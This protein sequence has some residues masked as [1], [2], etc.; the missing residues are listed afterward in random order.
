MGRV[1]F[2]YCGLSGRKGERLGRGRGKVL[3]FSE[4]AVYDSL[5]SKA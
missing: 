4:M 5:G 2:V 3:V 1:P